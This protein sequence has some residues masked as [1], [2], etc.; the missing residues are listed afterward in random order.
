MSIISVIFPE[1]HR[2]FTLPEIT[3][4][5]QQNRCLVSSILLSHKYNL[6]FNDVEE[7]EIINKIELTVLASI[8]VDKA[9]Y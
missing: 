9:S 2:F 5:I 4:K 1:F 8:E 3:I 6:I 7:I